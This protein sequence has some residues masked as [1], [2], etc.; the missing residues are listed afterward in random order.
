M[1]DAPERDVA[2]VAQADGDH[3][4]VLPKPAARDRWLRATG[5]PGPG[6]DAGRGRYAAAGAS[7]VVS[8][9]VAA[10]LVRPF[11]G[12]PAA[13]DAAASVLYFDHLVAGLRLEAFVNTTPKPLLTLVYGSLFALT[14]DWVAAAWVTVVVTAAGVAMASELARRV[15][16]IE[17]AVFATVALLG[18]TALLVET[19]WG[20]GLPWAF[21]LWA[22][23]GLALVRPSPRHGITGLFLL[24]AGLARQETFLILGLATVA[25]AWRSVRGPRPGRGAWLVLLGWLSLP[26]L[27]LH[28]LALTGDPLWWAR[29]SEI[30]ASMRHPLSVRRVLRLNVSHLLGLWP[31]VVAGMAGAIVL[32]WR[33]SWGVLLGLV[34]IG[35]LVSLLTLVLA[36]R[37]LVVLGHYLDPIDLAVILAASVG[38]GAILAEARRRVAPA[39]PAGLRHGLPVL[40]V[41]AAAVLAALLSSP[42]APASASA[43]AV[44]GTEADRALRVDAYVP[45]LREALPAVPLREVPSPGPYATPPP[46]A[47]HVFVP[48]YQAHRIA[49]ILDVPTSEL[50]WLE[51]TRVDLGAGYPAA[52]SLVYLDGVLSPSTI[53]PETA[54]LRQSSPTVVDGVRVVPIVA[55]PGRK[56]WI[57]RIE[58]AG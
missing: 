12:G 18:S 14:G 47:I 28:D 50:R 2:R 20:Q 5:D 38:A 42:F 34:A 24:L 54:V 33:R 48:R 55:D 40:T 43:R 57:V 27:C 22:A 41:A 31:F 51:P 17:A 6:P 1:G 44:I 23:A 4:R 35:P 13:T 39:I 10:W 8:L 9:V 3:A 37:R 36:L 25:L 45:V 21:A 16:G 52:G 19:S 7:F 49:G 30:S 15:A 11:D 32:A 26:L 58:P 56:V 53:V 29:V 46:D